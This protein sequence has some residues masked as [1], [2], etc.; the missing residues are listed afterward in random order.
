ML[1]NSLAFPGRV[2]QFLL[3]L[4]GKE[5]NLSPLLQVSLLMG[6]NLPCFATNSFLCLT[7]FPNGEF[8]LLDHLNSTALYFCAVRT[9]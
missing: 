6:Q 5:H 1:T 9:H 3:D 8:I 7:A 4:T 2:L